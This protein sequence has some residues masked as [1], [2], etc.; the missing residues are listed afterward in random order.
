[1]AQKPNEEPINQIQFDCCGAGTLLIHKD[2]FAQML[3]GVQRKNLMTE[4]PSA[5]FL[6]FSLKPDPK[7][8]VM[9]PTLTKTGS[10]ADTSF[11]FKIDIGPGDGKDC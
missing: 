11:T 5:G 9:K 7:I 3:D 8:G 4:G 10:G 2:L 6:Q 1:M